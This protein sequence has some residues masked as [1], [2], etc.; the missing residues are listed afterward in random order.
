MEKDKGTA[1]GAGVLILIVVAVWALGKEP[2]EAKTYEDAVEDAFRG[3]IYE[4]MTEAQA[5]TYYY[6]LKAAREAKQA[7]AIAEMEQFLAKVEAAGYSTEG[8]ISQGYFVH[9]YGPAWAWDYY[10]YEQEIA[11]IEAMRAYWIANN[12]GQP[13][14]AALEPGYGTYYKP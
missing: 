9:E 12:P 5:W 8:G 6:Q 7:A 1:V 10:N 2:A 3:T 13:L 11:R 4:G 14:P